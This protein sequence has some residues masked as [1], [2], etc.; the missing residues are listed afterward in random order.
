MSP[1]ARGADVYHDDANSPKPVTAPIRCTFCWARQGYILESSV[2]DRPVAA[3]D[4][5]DEAS[6][7]V[8]TPLT[9]LYGVWLRHAATETHL[10]E[11][12]GAY[13]DLREELTGVLRLYETGSAS[14]DIPRCIATYVYQKAS[15]LR[16]RISY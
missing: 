16:A 6:C 7:N 2:R 13:G 4:A 12:K 9:A 10:H 14:E 5:I 3:A 8:Q 1:V 15:P 11:Q